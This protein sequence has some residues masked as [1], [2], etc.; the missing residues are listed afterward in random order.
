MEYGLIGGRLGH[1]WSQPI[2]EA[3]GGY[4]YTLHP[5][6]TQAE[7]DA[8]MQARDFKAINVTIPYKQ[9]VIPYC[10]V[11]EPL[12][13][14]IGAV[15]TII[16]RD[17]KLYGYNTDYY[18]FAYL[19]SIH[20]V[21]PAGKTVMILG[22]GGTCR[23]VTAWCRAEGAVR[24]LT[25]GRHG[26]PG[27]LT[28]AEAVAQ[29]DV[30][31]LINTT[32]AGMYP[33]NGSCPIDPARFPELEAVLDVVYNPLCPELVQRARAIGVPAWAG[34]EMLVGQAVYAA[35]YFTDS[36]LDISNL[37][38]EQ[39]RALKR[40]LCNVSLIGMPGSGKSTLGKALAARLGK[41][42]VDLDVAIEQRAGMAIP[43]IFAQQGEAAFRRREAATLAD[44]SKEP[45]QV[46]A[47]GG[48][49]IKTPGNN[50]RLRQNG[51]V[52]WV[53]RPLGRLAMEGRPLSTDRARLRAMA[54]ERAPLY[55][56]MA[57]ATVDNTGTLDSALEATLQAFEQHFDI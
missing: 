36:M 11:V 8:F 45:G 52:L 24:I 4:A 44:I 47:C 5:L 34:L 56:A 3:I 27:L 28:Y 33:E 32:P 40:Q 55:D 30:Q 42:F 41:R 7:F 26:G 54:A 31:I 16:N 50:R 21:S 39:H 13:T 10:D 38:R 49:V 19:A 6:P 48:G 51:P 57:D 53:Q 12:A 18:G 15:N 23:T 29:Q 14:Q 9:A 37:L 22:S 25:V 46:I 43:D 20:G 35:E 17:G 2:H 1:S